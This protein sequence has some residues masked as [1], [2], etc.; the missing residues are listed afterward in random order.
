MDAVVSVKANVI[1]QLQAKPGFEDRLIELTAPLTK[2]ANSD[3]EPGCLTFRI[4]RS[5]S[6]FVAFEKSVNGF[7]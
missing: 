2:F 5:G 6:H 7:L 1:P 3:E 4:V